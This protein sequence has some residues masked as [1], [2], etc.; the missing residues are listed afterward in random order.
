MRIRNYYIAL[1]IGLTLGTVFYW[2]T[3]SNS[4]EPNET[5]KPEAVG[6]AEAGT[7]GNAILGAY[8]PDVAPSPRPY[9]QDTIYAKKIVLTGPDVIITLDSGG[10]VPGITVSSRKSGDTATLYIIDGKAVVGV[11]DKNTP[12]LP[13]ALFSNQGNGYLQLRERRGAHVLRPSEIVN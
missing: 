7:E 8:H 9:P 13:A 5:G 11:R 10:R 6:T 2:T 3:C 12:N 1:V 4:Q